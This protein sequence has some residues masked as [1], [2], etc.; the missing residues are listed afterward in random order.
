MTLCRTH[1]PL[2]SLPFKT[3]RHKLLSLAT[4]PPTCIDEWE[5]AMPADKG[6]LACFHNHVEVNRQI[7]CQREVFAH[8]KNRS[9]TVPPKVGGMVARCDRVCQKRCH[10]GRTGRRVAQELLAIDIARLPLV[11]SI[12]LL[13]NGVA[14]STCNRKALPYLVPLLAGGYSQPLHPMSDLS[15]R[16]IGHWA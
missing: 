2:W 10:C 7:S 16:L 4:K 8:Y 13:F 15:A 1:V 5:R 9:E 6:F 14:R 12:E 3:S 11:I